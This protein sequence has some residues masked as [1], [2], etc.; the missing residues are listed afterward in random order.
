MFGIHNRQHMN[1]TSSQ[2][3]A[4]A[5]AL[6]S[7]L[8]L[9]DGQPGRIHSIAETGPHAQRLSGLGLCEGARVF[10]IRRDDPLILRVCRTRVGIAHSLA[11]H[12]LVQPLPCPQDSQ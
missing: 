11:R 4:D 2:S 7:L 12:I 9:A 3:G 10:I 5:A 1:P 8:A 6:Q